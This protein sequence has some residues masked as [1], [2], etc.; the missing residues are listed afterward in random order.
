MLRITP[1]DLILFAK[2]DGETDITGTVDISSI[3]RENITYKVSFIILCWRE[4]FF[5]EMGVTERMLKALELV[6]LS[7]SAHAIY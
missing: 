3:A 2:K 6:I 7:F 1:C 5:S 4:R